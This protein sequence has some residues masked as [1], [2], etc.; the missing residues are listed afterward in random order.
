MQNVGK[1]VQSRMIYEMGKSVS[2]MK[3]VQR[4][5]QMVSWSKIATLDS[6]LS[7]EKSYPLFEQLGPEL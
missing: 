3:Y 2:I 7:T 4:S 5:G 1:S 6:D